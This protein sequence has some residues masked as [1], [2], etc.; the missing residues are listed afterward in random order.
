M[1]RKA[2]NVFVGEHDG[3]RLGDAKES[4]DEAEAAGLAKWGSERG[5]HWR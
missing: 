4:K 3:R 2:K 5:R 1:C